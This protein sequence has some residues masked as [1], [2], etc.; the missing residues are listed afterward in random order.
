LESSEPSKFTGGKAA[1][2]C[3]MGIIQLRELLDDLRRLIDI[4]AR[5]AV[6]SREPAS[7]MSRFA[8]L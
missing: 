8:G 3:A 7:A 1:D 5:S 2:E 6:A 4:W